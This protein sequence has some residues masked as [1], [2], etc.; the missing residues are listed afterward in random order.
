MQRSDFKHIIELPVLWGHM[1]ALGHVN[2]AEYFRYLEAGRIAYCRDV[3]PDSLRSA[4]NLVL[5]DIQCRFLRQLHYPDT[6]E[7]CT[8]IGRLGNR[9]MHAECAIFRQHE[10]DAVA[11]SRAVMVWFDFHTEQS[12]PLPAQLRAAIRDFE[13]VTPLE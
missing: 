8:R 4:A 11:T 9:S 5:A 3:L 10:D 6:I 7:V 1:D 12:M 13:P 2:N